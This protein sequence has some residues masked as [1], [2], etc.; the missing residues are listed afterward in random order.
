[1]LSCAK[2]A[3][4]FPDGDQLLEGWE[5]CSKLAISLENESFSYN[6]FRQTL[7]SPKYSKA[8]WLSRRLWAFQNLRPRLGLATA[9]NR[10]VT[11]GHQLIRLQ[12][13]STWT[14][15][16]E[17]EAMV[18]WSGAFIRNSVPPHPGLRTVMDGI[19]QSDIRGPDNPWRRCR[20]WGDFA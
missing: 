12:L 1:M 13:V 15:T 17:G 8:S 10:A 18:V 3:K 4:N 2:S 11:V 7:P 6:L 16:S 14:I 19:I 9:W 20:R 5:Y